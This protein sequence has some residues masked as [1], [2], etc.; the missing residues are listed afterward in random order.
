MACATTGARSRGSGAASRSSRPLPLSDGNRS[1][2]PSSTVICPPIRMTLGPVPGSSER[3]PHVRSF[4]RSW[5]HFGAQR[6]PRPTQASSRKERMRSSQS[7]GSPAS[8]RPGGPPD[9]GQPCERSAGVVG[10]RRPAASIPLR[11]SAGRTPRSP[12][13]A[14]HQDALGPYKAD[15]SPVSSNWSAVEY[16]SKIDRGPVGLDL[17]RGP[18]ALVARPRRRGSASG[19]TGRQLEPD[20]CSALRCPTSATRS[21]SANPSEVTSSGPHSTA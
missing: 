18:S 6:I 20:R 14:V 11:V 4:G 16:S 8:R 17:D 2:V 3:V 21:T 9:L 7:M 12:R 1:D 13:C 10:V 15:L 19:P 5:R